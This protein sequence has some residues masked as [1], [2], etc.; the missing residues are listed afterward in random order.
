MGAQTEKPLSWGRGM[1][2]YL[3]KQVK[4]FADG[5]I[6]SQAMQISQGYRRHSADSG[7]PVER[8]ARHHA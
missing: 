1:T 5:A 8:F 4:L 3:P 6:Y 2:A 7:H